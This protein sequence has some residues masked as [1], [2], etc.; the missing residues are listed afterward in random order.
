M[1]LEHG[2]QIVFAAG[3]C[4]A[5]ASLAL[6]VFTRVPR[7]ALIA[8]AAVIG[9]AAAG[10]WAAFAF[11]PTSSLAVSVGGLV[12]CALAAAASVG[13]SYL[14]ERRRA[15]EEEF[16]GAEGRLL[17]LIDDESERR[18]ADLSRTLARARADLQSTIVEEER[19]LSAERKRLVRQEE[20]AM[21]REVTEALGAA[22]QQA[23]QRLAALGAD[24]EKAQESLRAEFERLAAQQARLVTDLEGRLQQG[25]KDVQTA[26]DE[27]RAALVRLRGD[28]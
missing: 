17:R 20:E 15:A 5:M 16:L 24:L 21:A 27:Q 22:R 28:L 7:R 12:V 2:F 14:S 9:A 1:T 4:A 26:A 8:I 19:R 6:A 13:L 23:D 3:A 10:A 11:R 25:S 18:S